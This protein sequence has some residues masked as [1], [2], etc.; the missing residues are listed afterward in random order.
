VYFWKF[1]HV[2]GKQGGMQEDAV[3]C[4]KVAQTVSERQRGKI[5][6]VSLSFVVNIQ[7]RKSP[8]FSRRWRGTDESNRFSIGLS[9][10]I[11]EAKPGQ[12]M[13]YPIS[14]RKTG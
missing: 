3:A 13:Q 8:V 6:P 5:Q 11:A 9:G 2:K 10:M 12:L 4:D 7:R 1:V 14:Q